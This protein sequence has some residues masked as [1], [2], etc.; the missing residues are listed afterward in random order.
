MRPLQCDRR[1]IREA[2][3][4]SSNSMDEELQSIVVGSSNDSEAPCST[5]INGNGP[6]ALSSGLKSEPSI[7][8]RATAG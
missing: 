4:K 6:S 5:G 3:A 8:R 7:G 2:L 1:A